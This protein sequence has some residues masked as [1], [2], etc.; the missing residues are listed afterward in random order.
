MLMTSGINKGKFEPL[1]ILELTLDLK[2][3]DISINF[4][5]IEEYLVGMKNLTSLSLRFFYWNEGNI[6]EL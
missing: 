3:W 6:G 4:N 2:I 1:K 5:Q